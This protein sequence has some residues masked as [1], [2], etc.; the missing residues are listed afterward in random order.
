MS[1]ILLKLRKGRARQRPGHD[2]VSKLAIS[3][4]PILKNTPIRQPQVIDGRLVSDTFSLED[5][6]AEVAAW[7][8]YPPP[9]PPPCLFDDV[10]GEAYGLWW[11]AVERLHKWGLAKT[12]EVAA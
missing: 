12:D 6:R 3:S 8:T 9:F 11:D 5:Y 7:M 4:G 1:A 2:G 10:R